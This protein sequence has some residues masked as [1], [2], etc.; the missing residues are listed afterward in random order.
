M[1]YAIDQVWLNAGA[2]CVTNIDSGS[3]G[4]NAPVCVYV[5]VCVSVQVK[6]LAVCAGYQKLD[7]LQDLDFEDLDTNWKVGTHIQPVS[8]PA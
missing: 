7:S 3:N 1:G 2:L 6:L 5:C 8:P 4:I